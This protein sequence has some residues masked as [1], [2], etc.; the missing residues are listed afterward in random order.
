M[1]SLMS[2]V[3]LTTDFGLS[4]W[5]AGTMKGVILGRCP[6]TTIVDIT[7]DVPRGDIRSGAFA[8]WASC[9]HLPKGT[10]HLAVVDPGVGSRR[11]ALAV[12]TARCFFVGPDNGVLSWALAVEKIEA[13]HRIE[14]QALMLQ[15]V[16]ATFHGRDV[17]APIAAHLA[18][19][20]GIEEAGPAVS[21]FERLEWPEPR[22]T[23]DGWLGEV[24]YVDQF[25]NAI[26][27]LEAPTGARERSTELVTHRGARCPLEAF[28]ESVPAGQP[29]A[30]IGSADLIEVA[31]NGGSAA[32]Q[33]GL[34]PGTE[35]RL[36][37]TAR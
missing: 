37:E 16:S 20:G 7:H 21:D 12:K 31:V 36:V 26:T 11:P 24:L 28:Y 17:F 25:G 13:A 8:L 15:P 6:D 9:R 1:L 27:N 23:R 30:L 19:G 35:I 14:N 22:Q 3:T 2:I 18:C 4:D 32:A 5:F 33:L 10:V 29:L 34:T